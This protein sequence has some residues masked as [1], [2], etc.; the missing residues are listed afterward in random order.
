MGLED[1]IKKLMKENSMGQKKLAEATGLSQAHI[2]RIIN[3]TVT[4]A[5]RETLEQIGKALGVTTAYL[6]G[7]EEKGKRLF[8]FRGL[9]KLSPK[10]RQLMQ[11]LIDQM[12][13]QKQKK[14]E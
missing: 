7:E 13:R 9:E 14:K 5:T 8:A 1:K 12:T 6:L 4:N 3:G 11:G 10:E 2:S